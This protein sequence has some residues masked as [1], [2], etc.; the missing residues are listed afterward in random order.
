MIDKIKINDKEI[1]NKLGLLITNKFDKLF[2]LD[3]ILN[4]QYEEVFGYY[5]DNNLV[6]FIHISKLFET[7]DIINIVVDEKYRRRGIATKLLN[8]IFN[9]NEGP[10]SILLEV[11]EHNEQAIN[12]Y[13]KNG[14]TEINRRKNYYGKDTAIVMKRDV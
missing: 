9:L 8:Y 7:M 11:N 1:F 3:N 14:F 4:S 10:L 12:L 5:I 6:G 2:N 13:L